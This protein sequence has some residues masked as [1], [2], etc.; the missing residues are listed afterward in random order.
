MT[1]RSFIPVLAGA[2]GLG[3]AA[4]QAP[5][6]PRKGRLKQGA[7]KGCFGKGMALEDMC[8]ESA[9]LGLKG[10]D[11]SGPADW[12]TLKKYGLI[13]VMAPGCSGINHKAN[14]EKAE[15]QLTDNIGLA[16]VQPCLSL[17]KAHAGKYSPA[18]GRFL[19]PRRTASC[20]V[21]NRS[22]TEP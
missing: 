16:A 2:A 19:R 6:V 17:S 7:T 12:P 13:S 20:T 22:D 5:I 1:R 15:K 10:L 18:G 4:A 11:L 9:R 3:T 8:R 14:H 21:P